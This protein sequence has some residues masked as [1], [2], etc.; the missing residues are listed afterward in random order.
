[1]TEAAG[2]AQYL[3]AAGIEPE[4]IIQ[5]DA[6]TDTSENLAFSGQLLDKTQDRVVIVTN[7]FHLFRALKIAEKQGYLRLEGIAADSYPAML[8]NNLLRE[9][10]GVVKDFF[11]C[12][13]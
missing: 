3:E 6:S 10:L 12:N 2:M 11:V 4:R 7:N 8:P 5:E 1:M 13:L 9:F